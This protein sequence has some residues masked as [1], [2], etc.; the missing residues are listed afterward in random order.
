LAWPSG[1]LGNA[2]DILPGDRDVE[3]ITPWSDLRTT[4]ST[5]NWIPNTTTST[6]CGFEIIYEGNGYY[7]IDFYSQNPVQASPSYPKDVQ[8]SWD[9]DHP[10]VSWSSNIESDIQEYKIWK[11]AEGSSMIAATITHNP[12]NSIHSWIDYDVDKPGKFDPVYTYSYKVKAIDNT[13]KESLYSDQVSINGTG[14]LWKEGDKDN[15]NNDL[16]IK[17]YSLS[18][19]YP[20]PFNPTTTI[21]YALPKTGL[22]KIIVY[23][24]QGHEIRILVNEQKSPGFYQV[25]FDGRNLASGIYFYTIK[26]G[27]FE[28]VKKMVLLK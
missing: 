15:R 27:D 23:D 14:G 17:E 18:Q 10:E 6:N 7:T 22:V 4:S 16:V 28:V 19:N 3:V 13:S 9:G 20:N 2:G 12:N 5:Y 11:H 25:K 1:N 26:A 24:I 21:R 8:V